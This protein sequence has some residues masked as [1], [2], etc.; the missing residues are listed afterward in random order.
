MAGLWQSSLLPTVLTYN[1]DFLGGVS[2]TTTGPVNAGQLYLTGG[3]F[4]VYIG[5]D[6]GGFAGYSITQ[7]GNGSLSNAT[8]NGTFFGGGTEIVNQNAVAESDVEAN[9]G[10]GAI[11]LTMD[12]TSTA[13][14]SGRGAIKCADDWNCIEWDVCDNYE[15][16]ASKRDRDQSEFLCYGRKRPH[17][18]SDTVVLHVEYTTHWLRIAIASGHCSALRAIAAPQSVRHASC[19]STFSASILRQILGFRSVGRLPIG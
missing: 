16:L 12:S 19:R 2:L 18:V 3:P 6:A 4:A 1:V 8:L 5:A 14:Q 17:S 9:N 15:S 11:S 10:A 7:T 13:A